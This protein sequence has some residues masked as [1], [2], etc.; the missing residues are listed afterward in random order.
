MKLSCQ[1]RENVQD[2]RTGTLRVTLQ[3][4]VN[5]RNYIVSTVAWDIGHSCSYLGLDNGGHTGQEYTLNKMPVHSRA[6]WRHLHTLGQIGTASMFL[7]SGIKAEK[8]EKPPWTQEEDAKLYTDCNLIPPGCSW[9]ACP[10]VSEHACVAALA[11]AGSA[12]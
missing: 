7:E 12:H 4:T 2:R 11:L 9:T 3:N 6:S 5:N 1:I 10:C 8:E